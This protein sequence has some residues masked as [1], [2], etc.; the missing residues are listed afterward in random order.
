MCSGHRPAER[1]GDEPRAFFASASIAGLGLMRVPRRWE[2]RRQSI[3]FKVPPVTKVHAVAMITFCQE[4]AI[5]KIHEA[6]MKPLDLT[7]FELS[8][9]GLQEKMTLVLSAFDCPVTKEAL[10]KFHHPESIR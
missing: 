9:V 8:Q 7:L 2:V 6:D 1:F 5:E 4:V 3:V 10:E